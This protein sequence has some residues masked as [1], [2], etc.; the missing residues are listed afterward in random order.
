MHDVVEQVLYRIENPEAETAVF[1]CINPHSYAVALND[2]SF[3]SA[4][5]DSNWLVP[6]GVGMVV[7]SRFLDGTVNERLTGPDFFCAL[8]QRLSEMGGRRV[9]FLGS[10]PETL[11]KIRQRF[12]REFPGVGFAGA[13]SPPFK[14][15]FNETDT[16]AMIEA[17]HASKPDLLWVGMTAP[18]QE[19]WIAEN[20]RRLKV[21]VVA[22]VGA[23]FDFYAGNVQ[24]AHPIFQKLGLEWL[25][26]LLQEP[27]RLWRRMFISAPVFLWHVFKARFTG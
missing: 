16:R 25:P 10:T 18:K 17:V 6:D 24:R 22:A 11:A 12:E 4:L 23:V 3:S 9:F 21:P 26:R 5:K 13:Y 2:P 19:K 8:S 15:E 27:K 1:A 14:A 7:A 20:R